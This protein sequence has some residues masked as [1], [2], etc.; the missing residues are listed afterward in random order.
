MFDK[1]RWQD[2]SALM[3]HINATARL[4]NKLHYSNSDNVMIDDCSNTT[5]CAW[6]LGLYDDYSLI[7]IVK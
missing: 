4:L 1:T 3:V 2:E 6:E 7:K 5:A